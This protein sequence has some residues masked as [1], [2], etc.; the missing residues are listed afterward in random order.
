MAAPDFTVGAAISTKTAQTK[1]STPALKN[2][3]QAKIQ[4]QRNPNHHHQG[5]ANVWTVPLPQFFTPGF[6]RH[7]EQTEKETPA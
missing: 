6:L 2:R 4:R 1:S 7:R 5:I 3:N